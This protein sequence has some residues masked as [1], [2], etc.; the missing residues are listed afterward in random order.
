MWKAIDG[1]QGYQ[2][3]DLGEVKSGERILKQQQRD[4][5]KYVVLYRDKHGKKFAVHRL[6]AAAFL[7]QSDQIVCH[8]PLGLA[9]NS[10]SN[11][12]YG[13]HKRN[14]GA[15][16]RRDGTDNAG[17][18]NGRAKLTERDVKYIR[19]S[20][21]KTQAKQLAAMFGVAVVT[22]NKIWGRSLWRTIE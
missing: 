11:L 13:D 4:G 20:K 9:D 15:D 22:V 2:V 18:R 5:R 6:V 10:L 12:Y 14:L 21:G 16:K 1:Y 17:E 19:E 3:S 8:G 7:G